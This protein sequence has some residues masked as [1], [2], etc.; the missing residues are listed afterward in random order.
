[1]PY[2]EGK[3]M[4]RL[5]PYKKAD[6]FDPKWQSFVVENDKAVG[7][8]FD[9]LSVSMKSGDPTGQIATQGEVPISFDGQ[10]NRVA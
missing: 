7:E 3:I 9:G 5:K 8:L 4:K 1:V 6:P 10:G 2:M